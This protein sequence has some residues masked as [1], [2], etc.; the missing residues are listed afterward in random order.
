[1]WTD[2]NESSGN[3]HS[4]CRNTK[5]YTVVSIRCNYSPS[6]STISPVKYNLDFM[7]AGEM[8]LSLHDHFVTENLLNLQKPDWF[9]ENLRYGIPLKKTLQVQFTHISYSKRLD[10]CTLISLVISLTT[11][12]LSHSTADLLACL[13][14]LRHSWHGD[15][16]EKWR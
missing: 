1:M 3:T 11:L 13:L 5:T 15:S 14:F 4:A 16:F 8:I 7:N 12:S 10:L 9:F 6:G 2:L